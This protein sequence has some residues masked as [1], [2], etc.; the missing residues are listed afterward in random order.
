MVLTLNGEVL[1]TQIGALSKG[2]FEAVIAGFNA[3]YDKFSP[4]ARLNEAMIRWAWEQGADCDLGAGSEPYKT[5]WSRGQVVS[6]TSQRLA[7]TRRGV[8]AFA[9]RRAVQRAKQR[10]TSGKPGSDQR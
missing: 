3:E 5:F 4:G 9:L 7:V 1:A 10:R 6:L 8:A 2:K